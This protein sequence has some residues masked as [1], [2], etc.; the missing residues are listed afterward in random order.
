VHAYV[1][2][3]ADAARGRVDGAHVGD[4]LAALCGA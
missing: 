1:V 4:R 2:P 3:V